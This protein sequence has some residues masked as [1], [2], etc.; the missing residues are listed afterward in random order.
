MGIGHR[1]FACAAGLTLAAGAAVAL[2]G[3]VHAAPSPVGCAVTGPTEVP[4]T[5]ATANKCTYTT[6]SGAEKA[7]LTIPMAV[8]VT[9]TTPGPNGTTVP[10]DVFINP[11][12]AAPAAP[13][14][15]SSANCP[16]TTVTADPASIAIPAG[17]LVTVTQATAGS[18]GGNSGAIGLAV[19]GENPAG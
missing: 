19:V 6:V 3:H 2:S 5:P 10:H 1:L 17:T 18:V 11:V 16:G 14:P 9:W 15:A 12:C 7:V 8:D 13:N 4:T